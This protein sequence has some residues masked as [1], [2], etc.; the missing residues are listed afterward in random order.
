[1]PVLQTGAGYLAVGIFAIAKRSEAPDP[2]L[3]DRALWMGLTF[4]IAGIS[5]R[6]RVLAGG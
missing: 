6:R 3:A 2:A 1:M 4:L 5:G